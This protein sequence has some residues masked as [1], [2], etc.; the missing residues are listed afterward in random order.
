MAVSLLKP[1]TG[2]RSG[3]KY[4]PGLLESSIYNSFFK[5]E[6]MGIVIEACIKYPGGPT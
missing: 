6:A 1:P 2:S 4:P 3:V 5:A